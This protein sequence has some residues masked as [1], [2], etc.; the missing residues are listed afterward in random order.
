MSSLFSLLVVSALTAAGGQ[1]APV[2]PPS[3]E[4]ASLSFASEDQVLAGIAY[5]IDAIDAMPSILGQRLSASIPA[6]Q[7]TV[8]YSCPNEPR[9]TG[10]SRIT[11]D[12]DAGH[13]YQ[14]VCRPGRG[15]EIRP[16]DEC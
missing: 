16:S 3:S 6:G 12:F 7:R 10:G 15:A 8:W 1:A 5:G 4:Q 9:M 13:R 11:F 14:L 2:S